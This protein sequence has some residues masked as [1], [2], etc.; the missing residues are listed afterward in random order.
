MCSA[1]FILHFAPA[2]MLFRSVE[3]IGNS[4]G[5]TEKHK[6]RETKE[7]DQN[8]NLIRY[9]AQILQQDFQQRFPKTDTA[10]CDR[11]RDNRG[12]YRHNREHIQNRYASPQCLRRTVESSVERE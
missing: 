4:A 5:D 7:R 6:I 8:S 11:Q 10:G 12:Y 1:Y 9:A 2:G 3:Q